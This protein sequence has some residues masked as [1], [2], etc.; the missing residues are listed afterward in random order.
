MQVYVKAKQL[1]WSRPQFVSEEDKV[2]NTS[3]QRRNK[4]QESSLG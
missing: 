3:K 4:I 2:T 1:W